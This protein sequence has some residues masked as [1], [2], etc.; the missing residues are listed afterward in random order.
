MM[1]IIRGR[2]STHP[3]LYLNCPNL[4]ID[5]RYAIKPS[6][7]IRVKLALRLAIKKKGY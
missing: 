1:V 4:P 7:G 3:R 2:G 5:P 6:A